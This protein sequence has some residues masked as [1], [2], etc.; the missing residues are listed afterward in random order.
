M[1]LNEIRNLNP[2]EIPSSPLPIQ[3][4]ILIFGAILI[5]FL[6]YFLLFSGQWDELKTAEAEEISLKGQFKEKKALA[7]N[8]V[9]LEE[10]L[11]E[12]ELSFGALL[13]QLPSK[14]EMDSLLAEINQAGVGRGLQFELFRPRAEVKG[15]EMAELPIDIKLSGSYQE[16]ATFVSDVGQLSRIVTIGD[17]NLAPADKTSQRLSMQAVA[18]TYRALEPAERP[19][20]VQPKQSAE[21]PAPAQP[22]R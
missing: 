6:G 2:R 15:P 7:L 4:S 22:K 5:L 11:K 19:A 1:N 14:S 10:Q 8:R 18:K 12:I 21:R 9:A 3:I 13:K 20:P 16:L 17:I